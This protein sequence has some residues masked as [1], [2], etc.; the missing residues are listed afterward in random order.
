M[1]A[2]LL[3]GQRGTFFSLN[4]SEFYHDDAKDRAL[5]ASKRAVFAEVV[6]AHRF[7][8]Q[9]A[10]GPI[11]PQAV[12]LPF[13]IVS[14]APPTG[15]GRDSD[16]GVEATTGVF[17]DP[18]HNVSMFTFKAIRPSEP[19]EGNEPGFLQR[20]AKTFL[21]F[22]V[23]IRRVQGG[24]RSVAGLSGEELIF[25]AKDD[26]GLS[27]SWVYE[28]AQSIEWHRY[29]PMIVVDLETFTDDGRASFPKWNEILDSV[30]ILPEQ[31]RGER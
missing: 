24:K 4:W 18:E 20:I 17:D 22:A 23:G 19:D 15:D 26:P 1:K 29:V 13:G 7:P 10:R 9:G 6:A 30:Q 3:D 14:L 16:T 11:D 21:G 31:E 2:V 25:K 8:P 5:T 27:F 28:P 12:Y